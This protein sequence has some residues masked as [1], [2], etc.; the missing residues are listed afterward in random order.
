[1]MDAKYFEEIKAREQ[2]ATPG[3]WYEEGWALPDEDTG[4]F[5]ELGSTDP[6]AIFIAH[7][8]TD[9]PNLTVAL[10]EALD[11]NAK[12]IAEVERLTDQHRCDTHNLEAM[13][14]ILDQ[15][16]KNCENL[17]AAKD[18]Q[19]ATLKAELQ[20]SHQDHIDDFMRLKT[21]IATLGKA[22]EMACE[23]NADYAFCG[24]TDVMKAKHAKANYQHFIHQAQE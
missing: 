17:L 4:E 10:R 20:D 14:T 12:L 5:T 8:R 18:Q 6:D 23:R 3:P 1:M 2:A 11:E 24:G 19:I 9:V 15:Q 16:A 13:Q 21:E 7:A 22:L